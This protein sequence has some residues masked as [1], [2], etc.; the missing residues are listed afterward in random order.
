VKEIIREIIPIDNHSVDLYI[1]KMKYM[2]S[3][4]MRGN[5]IIATI[6][7]IATVVSF[8]VI[9]IP[10]TGLIFIVSFLLYLPMI[11]TVVLYIPAT[12][13]LIIKGKFFLALL[14]FIWNSIIVANIDN[15]MRGRFVP[16]EAQ[17]DNSLMFLSVLSGVILFGV[18]GVLYGPLLTVIG[19]T[20]VKMYMEVKKK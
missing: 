7:A 2:T 3:G 15:V 14:F 17:I 8:I 12:I 9:G 20:S 4:I 16:K 6:Q 18:M 1:E 11:G 5:F 13:Y 19:I 10:Y